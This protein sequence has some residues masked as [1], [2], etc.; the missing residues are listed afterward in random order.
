[1]AKAVW[2]LM[3]GVPLLAA[4]VAHAQMQIPNPLIQPV[5]PKAAADGKDPALPPL[6]GQSGGTAAPAPVRL[7]GT[8]EADPTVN[9]E[10]QI[11]RDVRAQLSS[12]Y[13][14]SIVGEQAVLRRFNAAASTQGSGVPLPTN[15]TNGAPAATAGVVPAAPRVGRNESM[16]VKNGEAI[17]Y[18]GDWVTLV[19]KVTEGK[20]L[21]YAETAAGKEAFAGKYLGKRPVVF[22]GEVESVSSGV[23]PSI[24]LER[25]DQEYKTAITATRSGAAS[26]ANGTSNSNGNTPST[27]PSPGQ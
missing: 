10:L 14:S 6:P 1:M 18:V 20:V 21:I 13:V 19:P 23:T 17:D 26:P 4:T 8:G 12:Y 3:L 16:I 7:P 5:K 2:R 22:F 11:L 24:T 25:K 15:N 27:P 9:A